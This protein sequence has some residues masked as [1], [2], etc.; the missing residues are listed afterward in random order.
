[1]R[2]GLGTNPFIRLA[3]PPAFPNDARADQGIIDGSQIRTMQNFSNG[4]LGKKLGQSQWTW[5]AP[6][7]MSRKIKEDT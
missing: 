4:R 3:L 2:F 7:L 1:M 6:P 5:W